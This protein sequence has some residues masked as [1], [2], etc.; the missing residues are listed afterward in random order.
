RGW[1]TS[2]ELSHIPLVVRVPGVPRGRSTAL[3]HPGD[4]MPTI[5]DYAGAERPDQVRAASLKPLLEGRVEQVRGFALSSWSL[6]DWSRYRPSVLRTEEWALYFW[7]GDVP[8]ELYHRPSD[9]DEQTNVADRHSD[10]TRALHA[11]YVRFLRQNNVP[12]RNYWARRLLLPR[13]ARTW[14]RDDTVPMS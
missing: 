1:P 4:L 5:L 8:P 14:R 2:P 3:C 6:R 13:F 9:P 7:R 11:R 10:V 12:A